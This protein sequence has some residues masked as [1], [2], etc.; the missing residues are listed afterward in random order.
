MKNFKLCYIGGDTAYFTTQDISLQW[1]DDWDDAPYEH[2]AGTPYEPGVHYYADGTTSKVESDWNED[3]T[4]RWEVKRVKFELDSWYTTP[5]DNFTNSPYSVQDINRGD[6]HWIYGTS[7]EGNTL[8]IPAG[9]TIEDFKE[10]VKASG[11]KIF[12]EEF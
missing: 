3:G 1:G 8:S 7:P 6:A 10:M 9:T 11:G 4:P 12:I 2:N 5:A